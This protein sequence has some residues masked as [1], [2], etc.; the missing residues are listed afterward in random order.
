MGV[1]TPKKLS[2]PGR[3]ERIILS[4][5]LNHQIAGKP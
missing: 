4:P 3:G 2:M 1:R 5:S